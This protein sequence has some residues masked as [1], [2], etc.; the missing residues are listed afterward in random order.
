M[1]IH[2]KFVAREFI[3]PLN[4]P[5]DRRLLDAFVLFQILNHLLSI[6]IQLIVIISVQQYALLFIFRRGCIVKIG[7]IDP[8][9]VPCR[10][11]IVG[12]LA[13][14]DLLQM[15]GETAMFKLLLE[16][17]LDMSGI[18]SINSRLKHFDFIELAQRVLHHFHN[19]VE[20][21]NGTPLGHGCGDRQCG[22][23]RITII[24]RSRSA[25]H[26]QPQRTP[27]NLLHDRLHI[28][29]IPFG[30]DRIII[31]LNPFRR[32][33]SLFNF[34]LRGHHVDRQ[35]ESQYDQ[36]NVHPFVTLAEQDI[37]TVK[38]VENQ[39]PPRLPSGQSLHLLPER[40][41][42]HQGRDKNQRDED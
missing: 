9:Y 13:N 40:E 23:D 34:D 12:C 36:Q 32:L 42:V 15:G 35:S 8:I 17:N 10:P 28:I 5:I 22:P 3:V 1:Q 11:P 30:A 26:K 4:P 6:T 7:S 25:G 16:S 20:L 29:L 41:F 18:I 33:F 2:I 21:L 24:F 19:L 31:K 27:E 39:Q 14:N 38:A 37:P